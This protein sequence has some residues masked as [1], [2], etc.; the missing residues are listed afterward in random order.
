MHSSN[1]V[2]KYPPK[3]QQARRATRSLSGGHTNRCR[4]TLDSPCNT[5]LT[6]KRN[7]WKE[8]TDKSIKTDY[9]VFQTHNIRDNNACV[10]VGF[11]HQ[12]IDQ[13]A[14]TQR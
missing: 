13:N 3:C 11:F 4:E 5:P 14:M 8:N 1:T 10:L 12:Q 6:T 9:R 7:H 2:V